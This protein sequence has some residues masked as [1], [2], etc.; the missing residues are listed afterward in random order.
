M[1][2]I[3]ILI[4]SLEIFVK[5]YKGKSKSGNHTTACSTNQLE[6]EMKKKKRKEVE[7]EQ[8]KK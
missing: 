1:K 6:N 7:K 4:S 2:R 3:M 8:K 5:S